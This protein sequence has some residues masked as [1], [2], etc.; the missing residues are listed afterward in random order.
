MVPMTWKKRPTRSGYLTVPSSLCLPDLSSS[1]LMI[2]TMAIQSSMAGP[3][4]GN[5]AATPA[6][7]M[8]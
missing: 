4:D 1:L 3:F 8:R 5:M 6:G 7:V 2:L